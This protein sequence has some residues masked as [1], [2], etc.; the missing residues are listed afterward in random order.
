MPETIK[1]DICVIGAGSGGLSVA[2]GASQM[3]AKVVLV[4]RGKMGGD[5]LNYGCVPS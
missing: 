4:E 2:A 1:A 5:C 3:G